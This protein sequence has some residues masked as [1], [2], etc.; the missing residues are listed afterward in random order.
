MSGEKVAGV[1][2]GIMNLPLS[3][4]GMFPSTLPSPFKCFLQTP[5]LGS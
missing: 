5:L 2:L 4:V 1:L 3:C